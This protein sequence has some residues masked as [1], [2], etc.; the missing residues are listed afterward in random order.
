MFCYAPA[1]IA[2]LKRTREVAVTALGIVA[3]VGPAAFR[4]LSAVTEP[5][6]P[7]APGEAVRRKPGRVR[8][9]AET[10]RSALPSGPRLLSPRRSS[11]SPSARGQAG[12]CSRSRPSSLRASR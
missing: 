5:T 12:C 7:D 2:L 11:R 3:W 9:A 4:E 10:S 6:I 8:D 1:T